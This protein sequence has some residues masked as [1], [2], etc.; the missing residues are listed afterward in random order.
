MQATGDLI[1]IAFYYLFHCGKYTAPRYVRQRDGALKRSM[2]TK[3]FTV[4]DVGFWKGGCQIPHK[5]PLHLLLQDNSVV[6]QQQVQE[7]GHARKEIITRI[8]T[9]RQYTR[10]RKSACA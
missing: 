1:L 8:K 3:E 2:R 6:V 9:T 10:A 4:G 5:F 7:E